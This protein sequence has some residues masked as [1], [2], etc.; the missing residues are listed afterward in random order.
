[1]V[2]FSKL[3]TVAKIWNFTPA[4]VNHLVKVRQSMGFLYGKDRRIRRVGEEQYFPGC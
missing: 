1:M 2:I 3:K 4:S